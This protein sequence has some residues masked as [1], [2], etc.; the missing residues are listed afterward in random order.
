VESS[1]KGEL[2]PEV[3]FMKVTPE[4]VIATVMKRPEEGEG[5]VIRVYE[6]HGKSCT[7]EIALPF[8]GKKLKIEMKAHEIK[9]IRVMPEK[10]WK[11]EEVNLLEELGHRPRPDSR[12]AL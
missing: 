2:G 11:M 8:F 5:L 3:E 6:A 9:T 12:C 7:A 4:N 1:H 10:E